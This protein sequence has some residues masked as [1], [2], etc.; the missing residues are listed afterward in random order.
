MSL[1]SFFNKLRYGSYKN[2]SRAALYEKMADIY[3]VPAQHIYEIAHGKRVRSPQDGNIF[4][5]LMTK[6]IIKN[7]FL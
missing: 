5:D 3:R 1:E 7:K 4:D 2:S 6:G